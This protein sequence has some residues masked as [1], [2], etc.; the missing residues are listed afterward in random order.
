MRSAKGCRSNPK[1]WPATLIRY[2]GGPNKLWQIHHPARVL[3]N[4]G[5]GVRDAM[6]KGLGIGQ[7]PLPVAAELVSAG[8]LVRVLPEWRPAPVSVY[9]VCPSSRYP[10][11][12]VRAFVNLCLRQFEL[13]NIAGGVLPAPPQDLLAVFPWEACKG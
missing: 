5:I 10:T 9:A 12:K 13:A 3:V 11:P 2:T 6:L 1:T 4:A 8:R 7:L